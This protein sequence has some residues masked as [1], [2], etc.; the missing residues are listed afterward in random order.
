[1]LRSGGEGGALAAQSA[2]IA[3][4]N[5]TFKGTPPANRQSATS[6]TDALMQGLTGS[7]APGGQQPG[8]AAHSSLRQEYRH[9]VMSAYTGGC[10]AVESSNVFVAGS[11]FS[12]CNARFVGGA[13]STL[14]SHM[15]LRDSRLEQC[16]ADMVTGHAMRGT[17]F[18][19]CSLVCWV[20][21]VWQ[22]EVQG[23]I[24]CGRQCAHSMR[25]SFKTGVVL[26][27]SSS[28]PA[29]SCCCCSMV[30]SEWMA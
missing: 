10:V 16:Y 8:S 29:A 27:A 24:D 30:A 4:I 5:S 12:H 6:D 14:D 23:A 1:M 19:S 26:A 3:I 2:F 18:G 13:I 9:I 7:L 15:V 20:V 28:C 21:F 17:G 22:Q 11:S 25:P